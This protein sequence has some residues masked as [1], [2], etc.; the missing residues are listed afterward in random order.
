MKGKQA[1]NFWREGVGTA[2]DQPTLWQWLSHPNNVQNFAAVLGAPVSHSF[3]PAY[4]KSFFKSSNI[5]FYRIHIEESE[6]E[7][8]IKTLNEWGLVAAAVTSPLKLVAGKFVGLGS[9]NTLWKKKSKWQGDNTDRSGA[10]VLLKDYLTKKI[11]VWGG[12]GVLDILKQVVPVASFYSS[13]N[14]KPREGFCEMQS[15]EVIVWGDPHNSIDRIPPSW[16]PKFVIDLSY[17]D[18]SPARL[19]SQ[20]LK[21]QYVSGLAMFFKQAEEQQ[22]IWKQILN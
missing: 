18:K 6:F 13:Q 10:E 5:P 16:K 8:A 1:I 3:S 17:H 7:I 2:M 9:A 12:G 19:Y 4:H 21:A 22:K 14:A 11:V 15:P 20:K